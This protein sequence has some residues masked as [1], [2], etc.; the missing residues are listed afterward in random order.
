MR[1][2]APPES[3]VINK[4]SSWAECGPFSINNNINVYLGAVW[5]KKGQFHGSTPKAKDFGGNPQEGPACLSVFYFLT[6][7]GRAVHTNLVSEL[8]DFVAKKS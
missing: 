3:R 5:G 8:S 7:Y 4:D 1:G 2:A 6:N